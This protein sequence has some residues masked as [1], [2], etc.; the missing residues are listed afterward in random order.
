LQF[1]TSYCLNLYNLCILVQFQ[2]DKLH[3]E[4]DMTS[5]SFDDSNDFS[6]IDDAEVNNHFCVFLGILLLV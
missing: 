6:D 1:I 2:P 4:D 3:G 5:N